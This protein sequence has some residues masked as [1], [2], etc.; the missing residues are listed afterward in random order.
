MGDQRAD[1]DEQSPE[2]GQ[3]GH[4]PGE[5]AKMSRGERA[6][7]LAGGGLLLARAIH[8]GGW[9]G[10]IAGAVGG[11]VLE[12]AAR[13]RRP[14]RRGSG[15]SKAAARR[16]RAPVITI[17]RS[18]AD[19]YAAWRDFGNLHRIFP[20][21]RAVETRADGHARWRL[22]RPIGGPIEWESE[23]TED[24]PGEKIAWRILPGA[25]AALSGS[26]SFTPGAED[27][28]TLVR[29]Q[30]ELR[31]AARAFAGV[32]DLVIRD[33]LRRFKQWMETGEIAT[34]DG[35]PSGRRGRMAALAAKWRPSGP[36]APRP[37]G[38]R[39]A[40]AEERGGAA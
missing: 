9:R 15:W 38:V 6:A 34:T 35:Q 1:T 12:R 2:R 11:Y 5:G 19:L 21:L 22:E 26:V 10:L 33:G 40:P 28:G 29:F 32:A 3:P 17:H 27:R 39:M 24:R 37:V 8:R 7:W 23:L 36:P 13:G 16:P 30:V 14:F 25:G 4:K 20:R 31:P 18:P